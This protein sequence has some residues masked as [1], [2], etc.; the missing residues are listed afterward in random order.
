MQ[1]PATLSWLI[2]AA[3]ASPGADRFL[4]ELGSHLIADGI[5]LAGGALAFA[6]PHPIIARRTWL[7]RAET[8]AVS[9]ALGFAGAA[10][11]D[12]A[13]EV[14]ALLAGRL[15][16]DCCFPH[17]ASASKTANPRHNPRC[18]ARMFSVYL[19]DRRPDCGCLRPIGAWRRSA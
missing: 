6:V 5:P 11:L 15:S 1:L 8:G 12:A 4:A 3:S 16:A 14:G 13:A 17:A 18:R 19:A 10:L 2:D 9:E 7:W